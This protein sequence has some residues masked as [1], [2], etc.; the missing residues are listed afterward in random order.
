MSLRYA[1]VT[2]RVVAVLMVVAM[3]LTAVPLSPHSLRM[4]RHLS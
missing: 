1:R 3:L 2:Q 4:M